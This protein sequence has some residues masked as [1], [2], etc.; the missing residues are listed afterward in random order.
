MDDQSNKEN[1]FH[2]SSSTAS[3]SSVDVDDPDNGDPP[4]LVIYLLDPFSFGVDNCDLA[5]LSS[6]ALL[7]C[8]HQI[9]PLLPESLRHHVCL[10]TISLES[11]FELSSP[12]APE[13]SR[14]L[15]LSVYSSARRPLMYGKDCKSLTGFGPA[16]NAERFLRTRK[17]KMTQPSYLHQPAFVLSPPP[18]RKKI[19]DSLSDRSTTLF[20]NYFLTEDQHWLLAAASDERGELVETSVINVDIPN[21]TRRKKASA[22]R[23]GLKK[24]MD[25]V[26]SVMAMALVPWRLVI[27]RVG[28]IGHGELRGDNCLY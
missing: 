14:G 5:R 2:P 19:D 23:V 3:A 25:W 8:F 26:L 7:K 11:V 27:G 21:K 1:S 20:V 4:A 17:H 28:R 24:L 18:T 15:A 16:S 12:H 9:L 6:L 22:R 13:H 10:H